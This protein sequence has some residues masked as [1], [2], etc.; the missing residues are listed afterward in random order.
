MT[1]YIRPNGDD[2]NDGSE[3]APVKSANRAIA[4]ANRNKDRE[5]NVL[6]TDWARIARELTA[7]TNF[8]KA[9]DRQRSRRQLPWSGNDK[10]CVLE[11]AE[12]VL[13]LLPK[14]GIPNALR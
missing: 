6:V 4:I 12:L 3:K 8:R 14:F 2:E 5:M 1:V 11:I 9:A 13:G 10:G 7:G